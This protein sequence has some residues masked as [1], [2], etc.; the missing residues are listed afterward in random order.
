MS[1]NQR[2]KMRELFID[3]A[4]LVLSRRKYFAASD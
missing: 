1:T 2:V 4:M 3:R